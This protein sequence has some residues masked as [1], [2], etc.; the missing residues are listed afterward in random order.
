M[1]SPRRDPQVKV[2]RH[3]FSLLP[4]QNRARKIRHLYFFTF[5][6][7]ST[8][9]KVLEKSIFYKLAK[10]PEHL[11]APHHKE[12]LVNH[13]K[14]LQTTQSIKTSTNTKS[15]QRIR[16]NPRKNPDGAYSNKNQQ[17]GNSFIQTIFS[18]KIRWR[19]I[20]TLVPAIFYE[21]ENLFAPIKL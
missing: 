18:Q 11:P 9:K 20:Q 5:P 21:A 6:E 8:P 15:L 3:I 1:M 19:E 14:A 7:S 2:A 10:N 12:A 4:P 16:I 17:Q 13:H